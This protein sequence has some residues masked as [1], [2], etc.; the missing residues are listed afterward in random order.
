MIRNPD[1]IRSLLENPNRE[2]RKLTSVLC[3]RICSSYLTKSYTWMEDEAADVTEELLDFD[4]PE[5]FDNYV[6][7]LLVCLQD[8]DPFCR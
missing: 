7:G 4:V 3:S 5:E 6:D 8:P 2:L 1:H